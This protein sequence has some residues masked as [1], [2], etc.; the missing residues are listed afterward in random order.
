[1]MS[2]PQAH[3]PPEDS[4]ST[5]ILGFGLSRE[6][7]REVSSKSRILLAQ[8]Q[9]FAIGLL[10][11]FKRVSRRVE[12]VSFAPVQNFP[13]YPSVLFRT[14]EFSLDGVPGL[15]L[16]FINL[17]GFKHVSRWLNLNLQARKRLES[18]KP[19]NVVVHGVHTPLMR[20]ALA[21]GR[22]GATR[23]ILVLTDAPTQVRAR[24]PFKRFLYG[25]NA[26]SVKHLAE[27]FD[28]II[29]LTEDLARDW[30][31]RVPFVVVPGWAPEGT[32][33]GQLQGAAIRKADDERI[34]IAYAGGLSHDYG[35]SDLVHA[36]EQIED[37][38][39]RLHVYGAGTLA[40]WVEARAS[41][42]PRIQF[43]GLVDRDVL[44]DKLR[45]V[46]LLVNPRRLDFHGIRWSFPSK[47]M[48][49]VSLGVPTMTTPMPTLTETF[50]QHVLV[51]NSDG[52]GAIQEG[53]VKFCEM[54][55][56]DRRS[57]GETAAAWLQETYAPGA[58]GARLQSVI[59]VAGEDVAQ[60]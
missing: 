42:D 54:S 39:L 30:A 9:S 16:G 17:L 24:N 28:F 36:F 33:A 37:E 13:K 46:D 15:S 41:A 56:D 8:T 27:R 14:Q 44:L 3:L 2:G 32:A 12:L 48:E 31:P 4:G 7:F 23:T 49:Y 6:R 40:D 59:S 47:L 20:F 51:T 58:V 18:L 52:V 34:I 29:A 43:Q 22:G 21:F 50:R 1:M 55:N 26:A 57:F 35:I 60:P 10:N 25:L 45:N 11:A 5:V 38:R 19:E 53:I